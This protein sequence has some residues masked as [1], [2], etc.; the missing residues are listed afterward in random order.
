[1][2]NDAKLI[3]E[4]Y[5]TNRSKV[6]NEAPISAD[7][8]SYTGSFKTAPGKGYGLGKIASAEGIDIDEVAKRLL[9]KIKDLFQQQTHELNGKTYNLYYPGSDDKFKTELIPIIQNELK[10]N[11]TLASYTARIVNNL[12]NVVR[13]V[14][15]SKSKSVSTTKD[16]EIATVKGLENKPVQPVAEKPAPKAIS[17][18]TELEIHKDTPVDDKKIKQ[19]VFNL[20]EDPMTAKEWIAEIKLKK[21]QYNDEHEDDKISDLAPDIFSNLMAAGV[22]KPTA[23]AKAEKEGEGSGEI[24]TIEDY[25]ED[26][27]VTSVA[28]EL[29]FDVPT[30]EIY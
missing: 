7:D 28:R 27:D 26:D 8:L 15:P 12:L 18:N 19:L 25:P 14:D 20:D 17:G 30:K 13:S 22:L 3:F 23:A 9:P 1:M 29:G 2:D 21:D 24:E 10:I 4:A 5:V 6:L 16:I 11:K